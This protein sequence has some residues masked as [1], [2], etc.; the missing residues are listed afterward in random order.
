M[1]L[2]NW[3]SI[4]KLVQLPM[5]P[6]MEH[7]MPKVNDKGIFKRIRYSLSTSKSRETYRESSCFS[8]N[9]SES[10][11][12]ERCLWF[13]TYE[14]GALCKPPRYAF[15]PAN[16]PYTVGLDT[17]RNIRVPS[18]RPFLVRFLQVLPSGSS[19]FLSDPSA[20][21]ILVSMLTLWKSLDKSIHCHAYQQ[22]LSSNYFS[23]MATCIYFFL[24][25]SI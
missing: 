2:G 5:S 16:I 9:L 21:Q 15:S 24:K 4:L 7:D 6:L 12:F 25:K 13:I 20:W 8:T 22:Y 10:S 23:S 19:T 14:R 18:P 1:D 3:E 17:F 11:S